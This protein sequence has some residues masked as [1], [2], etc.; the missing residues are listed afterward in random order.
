ME[1]YVD[2]K[3]RKEEKPEFPIEI[4]LRVPLTHGDEEIRKIVIKRPLKVKDFRGVKIASLAFD[5]FALIIG[6]LA[7]LPASVIEQMD[8]GDFASAM[9]VISGF[10]DGFPGTGNRK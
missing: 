8:L 3:P 10:L 4:M 6:R 9:E 1:I 2:E 7:G 5:D